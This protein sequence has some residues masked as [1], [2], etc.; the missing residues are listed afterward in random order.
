MAAENRLALA[1]VRQHFGN[2][3]EKVCS[4]LLDGGKYSLAHIIRSTKLRNSQVCIEVEVLIPFSSPPLFI[5]HI[6]IRIFSLTYIY[7]STHSLRH[8][9]THTHT[10]TQSLT[11]SYTLSHSLNHT[12]TLSLTHTHTHSLRHT[13]TISLAISLHACTHAHIFMSFLFF[14][15]RSSKV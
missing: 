7:I 1:L 12:H 13:R 9:Y 15:Y 10:H 5:Y 3:V 6:C 4:C 8:S 11:H 14:L 2:A